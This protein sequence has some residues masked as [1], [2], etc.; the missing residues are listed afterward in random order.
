M[1]EIPTEI[2]HQENID[3]RISQMFVVDSSTFAV[4]CLLQNLK[5]KLIFFLNYG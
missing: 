2:L 3:C 4:K 1:N 5:D